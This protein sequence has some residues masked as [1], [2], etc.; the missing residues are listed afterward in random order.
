MASPVRC[1]VRLGDLRLC[2]PPHRSGCVEDERGRAESGETG[3]VTVFL[4]RVD[5]GRHLAAA[6]GHLCSDGPVVLGIPRGGVVVAVEISQVLGAPLD[7]LVVGKLGVPGQKDLVMGAVGEGGVTVVYDNVVR[8]AGVSSEEFAAVVSCARAELEQRACR[9]RAGR[10]G[11]ALTGRTVIVVDDG[12]ATGVSARTACR[13]ARSRGA[14]RVVL[15]VPVGPADSMAWLRREA[16]EIDEVICLDTREDFATIA[17]SYA[18]FPET[19]DDDVIGLLE[20]DGRRDETADPGD[21]RVLLAVG[22]ARLPGHLAIPPDAAGIVV[23]AADFAGTRPSARG[24]FMA[25]TLHRARLG[26]LRVDLRTPAE[27]FF[28]PNVVNVPLLARRLS[29]ATDW[30]G[31]RPVISNLPIGYL[32]TG[33]AAA[34]ALSAAARPVGQV[35]AVVSS[36]GLPHL[37]GRLLPSVRAPILLIVGGQDQR[38]LEL[39]RQAQHEL[40]CENRLVVIPGVTHPLQEPAALRSSADLAREWF[41]THLRPPSR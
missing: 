10:R 26:T 2:R 20:R 38:T 14:R 31:H 9:L 33:P 4:D 28:G 22:H 6:V 19:T 8:V 12:V 15:A 11:V 41:T 3:P 34:A 25:D 13:V 30:L 32:G 24:E 21:E 1:A 27:E 35:T 39:N 23:F 36:G 5:A 40:R 7:V 29:E 18:D 17:D 16:T 37:A